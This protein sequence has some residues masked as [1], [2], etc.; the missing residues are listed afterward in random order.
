MRWR[1]R[2]RAAT[3]TPRRRKETLDLVNR[4]LAL[5]REGKPARLVERKPEEEKV[6]HMLGLLTSMPVLYVCNVDEASAATG[7][8]LSRQVEARA[9]AE[10]A[11]CVVISAKIEAEIAVLPRE[12]R[13][14]VSRRR[15][16]QG[17]RPRPPDPRRL[18]AARISSPISPPGRRR[19]AP[20]PITQRHQGAAGR[21]R[22][23]YRLRARLH[24]RR[25]H[26]L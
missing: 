6:F 20:G 1:R 10:G 14:R 9:K 12:E 19:R 23:P 26:R 3:R 2:P 5:L 25:D 7:N 22:D 18:R 4:S 8:E 24:P 13:D 21:G 15:R 17:G 11:G 16:P